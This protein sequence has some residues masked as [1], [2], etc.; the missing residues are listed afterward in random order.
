MLEGI[1]TECVHACIKKKNLLAGWCLA[2]SLITGLPLKNYT[3]NSNKLIPQ[4]SA[5]MRRKHFFT[6]S[7]V[8]TQ[9]HWNIET[10]DSM[11]VQRDFLKQ[12]PIEL[13]LSR[14]PQPLL[15]TIKDSTSIHKLSHNFQSLK[16]FL[17]WFTWEAKNI[18]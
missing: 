12:E 18:I 4:P 14:Q 3:I 5:K 16:S 15:L 17:L 9:M 1:K 2:S 11:D 7:C 10:N 13:I 8:N 6:Y